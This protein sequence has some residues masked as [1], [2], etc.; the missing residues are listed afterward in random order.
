M[1]PTAILEC[2]YGT[3]ESCSARLNVWDWVHED[4]HSNFAM[5]LYP[6]LIS[7]AKGERLIPS[8]LGSRADSFNES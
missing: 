5:E 3:S 1:I 7:P 2:M 8:P 6:L 4:Q